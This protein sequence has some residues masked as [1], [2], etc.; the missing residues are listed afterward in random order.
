MAK[1]PE[2]VSQLMERYDNNQTAAAAAINSHPNHFTKIVHGQTKLTD[3][4]RSRIEAVLNG[5]GGERIA[6]T[7]LTPKSGKVRG[8]NVKNVFND[9]PLV[10]ELLAKYDGRRNRAAAALGFKATTTLN[11]WAEDHSVFDERAQRRV[12]AALRGEPPP[13]D[14]DD[15]EPDTYKMG[16][17]V[18]LFPAANFERAMDACE[19]FSGKT[20]FKASIR[21][22]WLGVF[23]MQTDKMKLWKK[24]MARDAIKITCP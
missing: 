4:M 12:E 3:K 16:F 5:T 23:K 2:I 17:A 22:E 21:T 10:K 20:V 7:D 8:R 14:I 19:A 24:L 11:K 9:L 13:S 18:G 6:S 15:D 1:I